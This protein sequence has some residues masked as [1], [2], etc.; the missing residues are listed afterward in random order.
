MDAFDHVEAI[1]SQI[2]KELEQAIGNRGTVTATSAW[3]DGGYGIRIWYRAQPGGPMFGLELVS[4]DKT[5]N[6]LEL[7]Q[8]KLPKG[9]EH[10]PKPKPWKGPEQAVRRHLVQWFGENSK[11]L[12]TSLGEVPR[13]PQELVQAIQKGL[14][15][16]SPN[17][18]FEIRT[19]P[20]AVVVEFSGQESMVF[21][22]G[23]SPYEGGDWTSPSILPAMVR[24]SGEG[25][26][27]FRSVNA[28][29]WECLRLLLQWVKKN[30]SAFSKNR[31][32]LARILVRYQRMA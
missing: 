2:Q 23:P 31:S 25:M 32:M 30:A 11:A 9:F 16:I 4:L 26:V 19:R 20:Q 27:K 24:L 14:Q 5:P 17:L 18:S 7:Q 8:L 1:A 28:Q 21:T 13:S 15:A 29:P 22:F 6:L 3:V 12:F 10:I